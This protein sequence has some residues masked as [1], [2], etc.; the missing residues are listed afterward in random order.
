MISVTDLYTMEGKCV[1]PAQNRTVTDAVWQI[2]VQRKFK[3]AFYAVHARI[4]TIRAYFLQF[5]QSVVKSKKVNAKK[6][7][8]RQ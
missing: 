7:F 4:L 5:Y 6:F 1:L 3:V 2:S 8:S